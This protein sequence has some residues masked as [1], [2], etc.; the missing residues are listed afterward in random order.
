MISVDT[1]NNK[2]LFSWE[3]TSDLDTIEID[4]SGR[5]QIV[6][7][8]EVNSV[9][10]AIING[11]SLLVF[12]IVDGVKFVISEADVVCGGSV[13]YAAAASVPTAGYFY[14]N[15]S[16]SPSVS[17]GTLTIN[18]PPSVVR[19]VPTAIAMPSAPG[20]GSY[21]KASLSWR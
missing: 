21:F 13:I 5:S 8:L 10:G 15:G 14:M 19:L 18:N 16:A 9:S 7:G 1:K 20:T 3:Q 6:I 4:C 11:P 12:G 2:Q 17:M